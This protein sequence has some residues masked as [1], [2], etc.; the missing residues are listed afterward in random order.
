MLAP[1]FGIFDCDNHYYEPR[2]AFQY[3]PESFADRAV[4]VVTA[5]GKDRSSSRVRSTT[6]RRPPSI[7]CRPPVA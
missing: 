2:D 1:A 3:V 6:S 7:C 4:K 5:N